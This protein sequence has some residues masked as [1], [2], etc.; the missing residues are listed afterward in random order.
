MP[1]KTGLDNLT[2]N[3]LNSTIIYLGYIFSSFRPPGSC[4][5]WDDNRWMSLEWRVRVCYECHLFY[6]VFKIHYALLS[7]YIGDGG[8][9]NLLGPNWGRVDRNTNFKYCSSSLLQYVVRRDRSEQ[10][11][12]HQF[13]IV[14]RQAQVTSIVPYQAGAVVFCCLYFFVGCPIIL[15]SSLEDPSSEVNL[16]H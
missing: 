1:A 5:L 2:W 10:R 16:M 6:C 12:V 7:S 4:D 15:N 11:E 13:G 14:V 8:C 9:Q 3:K